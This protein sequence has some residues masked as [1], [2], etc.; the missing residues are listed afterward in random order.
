ML[1]ISSGLEDTED[2]KEYKIFKLKQKI[3]SQVNSMCLKWKTD[4]ENSFT[5]LKLLIVSY[6][7]KESTVFNTW[8][9]FS[10]HL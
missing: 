10:L 4:L 6:N 1:K 3:A 7:M 2:K 5:K 8:Q 9:Y